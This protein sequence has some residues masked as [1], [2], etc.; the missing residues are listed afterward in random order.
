LVD[1]AKLD[2]IEQLMN[3]D[4]ELLAGGKIYTYVVSTSTPLAT[5]V[6]NSGSTANTNPVVL[7]SSGRGDLWFIVGLAY[8]VVVKTSAGVTL[9]TV[10]GV[11]AA[12]DAL[13]VECDC[14]WTGPQGTAN[15][16]LS[17]KNIRNAWSFA[18]NWAGSGG[19][20]PKTLPT[21]SYTVTIKK[22]G[23][24]VGTA[25][26]DTSGNWAF[27]TSGAAAVSFSIGD[28]L[29]FYG[30]GDTTIADFSFTLAG[31]AA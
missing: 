16:W 26:C 24:S 17:G 15:A 6:D 7:D 20:A 21:A 23:S 1:V 3:N 31:Q 30:A 9:K 4:G 5:Y 19:E 14:V 29:D 18:S 28:K 8:K 2:V 12:G 13:Q 11:K 10:D 25:I 22:N 27:A